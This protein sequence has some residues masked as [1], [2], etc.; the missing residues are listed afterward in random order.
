MVLLSLDGQQRPRVRVGGIQPRLGPRIEV[1]VG[2]LH[3]RDSG[4]RHV[5][6]LVELHN[7]GHMVTGPAEAFTPEEIAEAYDTNVV[8]T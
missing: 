3:E 4:R 6:A 7:A 1:G 2:H 5:V 8:G